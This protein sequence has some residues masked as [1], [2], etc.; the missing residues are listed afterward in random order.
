MV[1]ETV[2]LSSLKPAPYNPRKID[3]E[4]MTALQ[5]SLSRFGYVEPLV[6]NKRSGY[7]V[8]GH[9][10]LKAL[11]REKR[12]AVPV[13]VVDL[14]EVAERQLNVAL[15]NHHAAGQFDDE[16]LSSLLSELRAADEAA[17]LAL[18]LPA[19]EP[20]E[21][22]DPERADTSAKLGGLRYR[23]VVECRNETEMAQLL[24][25]FTNEGLDVKGMMI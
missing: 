4:A 12:T 17:F 2:P 5:E 14:D 13:V 18:R 16:K 7:V 3:S 19:L 11:K 25:R 24:D 22:P 8:G 23:I 21:L 20:V 9:Q 1:I 15:N 6:W 10:R